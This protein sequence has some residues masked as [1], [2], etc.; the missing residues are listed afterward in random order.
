MTPAKD[1]V[2][3]EEIY[4]FMFNRVVK[5]VAS[6]GRVVAVKARHQSSLKE[7]EAEMLD[8]ISRNTD[9]KAPKY[10]GLYDVENLRALV[11]EF[12]SGESLDKLWPTMAKSERASIKDQFAEQLRLFRNC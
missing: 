11:T 8:Y 10:L 9:I 7:S 4:E 1:L 3:G 5:S 12:I 6:N 2:V